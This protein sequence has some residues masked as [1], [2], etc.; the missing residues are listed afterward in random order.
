MI[1]LETLTFY[2]KY[3]YIRYI[4]NEEEDN[5]NMK[6]INVFNLL[7]FF[8][9]LDVSVYAQRMGGLD[10]RAINK[11]LIP[12]G[13]NGPIK[14]GESA[15]TDLIVMNNNGWI[16]G[17]TKASWGAKNCHL[18]R[19]DGNKV[20]HIENLTLKINGQTS[21]NDLALGNGNE[22][23]GCTSTYNEILDGNNYE[24]GHLFIYN[25]SNEK[26]EDLGIMIPGQGINCIAVDTIRRIIYG[27]TYPS[28]HL[29][30]FNLNTRTKKDYG[31]IMKPWKIKDLGRIYWRGVPKVLM[32]DDA[33]TVYYSTYVDEKVPIWKQELME[34]GPSDYTVYAGGRIFRFV[35]GEEKP[36]FTGAII[37]SQKGMDSDRLY[38]NGIASAIRAQDGGFWCGTINDG[39]L[40]KF[41]P[42]TSTVINK[43]KAFQYWNLKSLCYGTD[44]KLYMLGGRDEDNSWLLRYD[45]TNGS[46]DCLGW[47]DNTAQCN[48]IVAIKDKIIFGENLRNSFLWIY[49]L[50]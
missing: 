3:F 40:F 10:Q 19:T 37:P 30:S 1:H 49:N 41:H 36:V 13:P 18:F 45:P 9:I 39:F 2:S 5:M 26:I 4:N 6:I 29:F 12:N 20:E 15:I 46:M 48:V 8:L 33:G 24:G 14:G 16:Y 17:S 47:P 34:G 22:I 27:V 28:C 7:L 38:E 32:I 50:N 42:S 35:H 43:G 21:I 31:L 23:Y 25:I 44:G 11:I